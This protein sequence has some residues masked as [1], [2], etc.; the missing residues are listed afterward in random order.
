MMAARK[1]L[2]DARA[3]AGGFLLVVVDEQGQVGLA[4]VGANGGDQ[5]VDAL[6]IAR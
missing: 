2:V 4:D 6:G 3:R 5:L 1:S